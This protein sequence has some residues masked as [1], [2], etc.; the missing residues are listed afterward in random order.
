MKFRAADIVLAAIMVTLPLIMILNVPLTTSTATSSTTSS[1]FGQLSQLGQ[2]VYAQECATCHGSTG[3]GGS[4]PALIGADSS[5]NTFQNADSLLSFIS[6][7]MPLTAPGSLSQEQYWQL[8][9]FLVLQNDFVSAQ[10]AFDPNTLSQ[11]LLSLTTTPPTTTAVSSGN[12]DTGRGLFTGSIALENKGIACISCHNVKGVGALG[13][14]TVGN[15]LSDEYAKL[16]NGGLLSLLQNIP[17]PIMKNIYANHPLTSTEETDLIAF[18]GQSHAGS[19]S[20]KEIIFVAI[21]LGGFL[22]LMSIL[23]LGWRRRISRVRH[24]LVSGA[25]K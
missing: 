15:D 18:L 8:L 21:G 13:G 5:L 4:A 11:I 19:S 6:K 3:Q 17:F 9:S 22:V 23:V 1:S 14:G 16:G 2:Q 24:S 10:T 25:S 12:A 20:N 7:T